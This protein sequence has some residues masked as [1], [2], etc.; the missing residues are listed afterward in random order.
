[1][2]QLYAFTIA[3]YVFIQCLEQTVIVLV[4]ISE[5]HQPATAIRMSSC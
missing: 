1:M 2:S 5:N 4:F 3:P